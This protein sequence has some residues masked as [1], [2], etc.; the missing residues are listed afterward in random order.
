MK[1]YVITGG[2]D[3]IGGAIARTYLDR[4][5]EVV[6]VG[7]DTA[8][9]EAWLETARRRDAASRAHFL[10][11]DLSLLSETGALLDTLR[12]SF[13]K[14]DAL[15]LCA[16]HFRTTRLVTAEGFE[17]TFAHFYLSR[18]VLSH[19]LTGLLDSAD[20][21]V[22]VNVAGPGGEGKIHW[23]DLQLTRDYDG[24]T[25]LTQ[26]GRLNDLLGV[27]YADRRPGTK[28]R[29]VLFHPGTVSTGFSGEYTP[30]TQARIADIR[31]TAQ[32]VEEAVLPIIRVLDS[33]P[34]TALSAFVR[35]TPLL[36]QGPAFSV[37]QARRLRLRTEGILADH[38]T[39]MKSD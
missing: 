9:G 7:R 35:D 26:G 3:G 6:V 20:A 19:G 4:G 17:N 16:R 37:E 32:P 28:V 27:S 1:T 2:T 5:Q 34:D 29:Y 22:I 12:A 23:N 33:P 38:A 21:P 30:D 25:A 14:V 11:A 8:K 15:V 13:T 18:F 10:R 31:R 24:H 36:P 39:A